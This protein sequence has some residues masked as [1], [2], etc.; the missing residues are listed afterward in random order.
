MQL[1]NDRLELGAGLQE[2]QALG[3]QRG[4]RLGAAFLD[5]AGGPVVQ[6]LAERDADLLGQTSES[7]L[8]SARGRQPEVTDSRT[9]T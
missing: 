1:G 6:L 9:S 3:D 4:H 2:F 7:Y 5:L 8:R